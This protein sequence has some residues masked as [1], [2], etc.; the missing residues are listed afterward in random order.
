MTL[1]YLILAGLCVVLTPTMGIAKENKPE[2]EMDMQ[3]IMKT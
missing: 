1:V 3:A 2:K